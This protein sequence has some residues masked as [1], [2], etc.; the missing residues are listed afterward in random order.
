[1][2]VTVLGV[3]VKVTATLGVKGNS[4]TTSALSSRVLPVTLAVATPSREI[5]IVTS[6]SKSLCVTGRVTVTVTSSSGSKMLFFASNADLSSI[7]PSGAVIESTV[8]PQLPSFFTLKVHTMFPG[9]ARRK[10]ESK[11]RGSINTKI[12]LL[13][14]ISR[15]WGS[16]HVN[17]GVQL[18]KLL[19]ATASAGRKQHLM[20]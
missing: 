13:A 14:Q 2:D 6:V 9:A 7:D 4:A 15:A 11:V 1:M 16:F 3:A 17:A 12:L 10:F 18:A 19:A 20:T 5:G 8:K